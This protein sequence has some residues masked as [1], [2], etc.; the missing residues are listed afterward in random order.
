MLSYDSGRIGG[1]RQYGP[2]VIV[3]SGE[4]RLRRIQSS[5]ETRRTILRRNL[6]EV[7]QN[8]LRRLFSSC[9]EHK[10]FGERFRGYRTEN[11]GQKSSESPENSASEIQ[12]IAWHDDCNKWTS[13]ADVE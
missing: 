6:S 11:A 3:G 10:R 1:S 5:G 4:A 9:I 7:S 12:K 8:D 13:K 2:A